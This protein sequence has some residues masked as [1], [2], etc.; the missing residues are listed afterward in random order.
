MIKKIRFYLSCLLLLIC[1]YKSTF[2]ISFLNLCPQHKTSFYSQD[3][4]FSFQRSRVNISNLQ[5]NRAYLRQK[6]T[7]HLKLVPETNQIQLFRFWQALIVMQI[8]FHDRFGHILAKDQKSNNELSF[9][10][11]RLSQF[12]MINNAF[13]KHFDQ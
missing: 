5:S 10:K 2:L 9:L 1:K 3:I 4:T 13:L 7:F 12:H 11:N 6:L 8:T